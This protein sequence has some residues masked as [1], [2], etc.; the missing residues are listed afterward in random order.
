MTDCPY[1]PEGAELIFGT[2]E[3]A[4][5]IT[6]LRAGDL[7]AELIDGNLRHIFWGD[8][9]VLRGIGFVV[10]DTR[11]GTLSPTLGDVTVTQK[12][13]RF[14]VTYDGECDGP[15]GAF[16][17]SARIEGRFEGTLSF[18][19]QGTAPDGIRTNRIGFVV[20]HPL[21]GVVGRALT[22]DHGEGPAT[23]TGFPELVEPRSPATDIARLTHSP[24]EGLDLS[25]TF[26]GGLF[27]MEDHRNWTDAS[28]KTYFRPLRMGFPYAIA[29]NEKVGQGVI[30]TINGAARRP[31]PAS[32]RV[33][34]SLGDPGGTIPRMGLFIGDGQGEDSSAIAPLIRDVAPAFVLVR[35]VMSGADAATR[36]AALRDLAR[37]SGCPAALEVVV[38]GRDAAAE[39]APLAEWMTADA[40]WIESLMIV[41][42]RDLKTRTPET[43]PDGEQALESILAAARG[44]FPGLRI[45]GG[46]TV[47]FPELN[48]NR[49]AKGIDFVTHATQ[50]T[51]HDCDDVSVM[52]TLGA[53]PDVF[54]S[55]R[56][57]VGDIPYRIGPATIGMPASASASAPVANPDGRRICMAENDPRQGSLFGAAFALGHAATAAAHGIDALTLA[58]PSGPFGMVGDGRLSRPI[59]WVVAGLAALRECGLIAAT[60]SASDRL[61]VLAAR[62]GDGVEL[63]LAN[64]TDRALTVEIGDMTREERET[65][66]A[67]SLAQ[68]SDPRRVSAE[69]GPIVLA[70]YAV[71]RVTGRAGGSG[72]EEAAQ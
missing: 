66:D 47:P 35:L 10:R 23:K 11:W 50:A 46:M 45:G 13:D 29:A 49:P 72:N 59:A 6:R 15:D 9:E 27:E 67:G 68:S 60:S 52:E 57:I 14:D 55:V 2:R 38:P 36:F 70:A 64:L 56:A 20:L 31:R 28:F 3:P 12:K 58:A 53:L 39:L 18:R 34:V 5:E 30:V 32:D 51:L 25:V 24:R 62:S 19:A 61:A 43:I 69:S 65:L 41:P 21:T 71:S 26:E 1:N 7:L 22:V 54:A 17:F 42:A 48:R 33:T 8:I 37:T 16:A 40:E 63:W 4:A 44:L